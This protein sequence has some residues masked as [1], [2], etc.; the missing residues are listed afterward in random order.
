[1]PTLLASHTLE[2]DEVNPDTLGSTINLLI[3]AI[4]GELEARTRAGNWNTF[5][6]TLWPSRDGGVGVRVFVD[7]LA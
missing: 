2:P 6:V 1:M 3:G 4:E 5:G 7:E